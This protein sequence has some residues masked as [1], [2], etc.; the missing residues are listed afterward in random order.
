MVLFL[1]GHSSFDYT[2]E[3]IATENKANKKVLKATRKYYELHVAE[4]WKRM[5][6]Q[7]LQVCCMPLVSMLLTVEMREGNL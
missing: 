7:F 5:N 4:D 6:A 3:A 1:I 2:L